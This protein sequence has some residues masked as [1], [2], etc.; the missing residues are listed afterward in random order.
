MP[1]Y[2]IN[3]KTVTDEEFAEW[4]ARRKRILGEVDWT[5][6]SFR[7]DDDTTYL[8]GHR[9]GEDLGRL[10]A[11]CRRQAIANARKAGINLQGKRHISQ[12]GPPEDPNS[13]VDGYDEAIDKALQQGKSITSTSM[14]RKSHVNEAARDAALGKDGKPKRTRLAKHLQAEMIHKELQADPSLKEKNTMGEM[15][16]M[17]TEKYGSRA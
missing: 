1:Q 15:I 16:E 3:G 9:N 7:I 13:W 17:V 5:Q 4:S 6:M 14:I 11:Y 8:A 2:K 12:L 10:P